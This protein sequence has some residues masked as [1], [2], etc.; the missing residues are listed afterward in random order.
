MRKFIATIP[1]S[2]FT[3]NFTSAVNAA[4]VPYDDYKINLSNEEKQGMRS[5]AEGREGYARLISR[6]ATQF[7]DS[8]SRAD[9]PQ[10]LADLLTYYQNLEAN[11]LALLQSLE[12]IVELQLGASAD[13]MVKV[14]RFAQNLQISRSNEGS[15]DLA[16]E[17]VDTYNSRFSGKK[18]GDT[19]DIPK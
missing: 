13:I 17:E 5:M 15:L 2:R 18:S 11:R 8:L 14:D 6:I 19:P 9:S 1:D 4:I 16:M 3:D 12:T 7:P 10:D